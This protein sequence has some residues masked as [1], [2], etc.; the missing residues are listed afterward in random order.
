MMLNLLLL[1]DQVQCE[2]RQTEMQRCRYD[3][4][5]EPTAKLL[6]DLDGTVLDIGGSDPQLLGHLLTPRI[7]GSGR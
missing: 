1:G 3:E 6:M 2:D 4:G 5:Q 7:I